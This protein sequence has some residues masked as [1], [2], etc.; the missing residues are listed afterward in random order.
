MILRRH[1]SC[2]QVSNIYNQRRMLIGETQEL[3]K[4]RTA[5]TLR[6]LLPILKLGIKDKHRATPYM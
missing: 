5:I 3:T 6:Y 4:S 1:K 2:G